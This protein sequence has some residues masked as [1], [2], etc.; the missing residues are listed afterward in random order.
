M[1][2]STKRSKLTAKA[3]DPRPRR[4][5]INR[6]VV[7]IRILPLVCTC[8]SC[9]AWG[10]PARG[11][12][13]L[14]TNEARGIPISFL[15]DGQPSE[16]LLQS[17]P[18]S[19]E[20]KGRGERSHEIIQWQ[21]PATELKVVAETRALA[22]FPAFEWLLRF[23]NAGDADSPI[24][25]QVCVLDLKLDTTAASPVL[26][27]G[28]N[29]DDCSRNSFQPFLK[30]I[31]PGKGEDMS[32]QG[33]RPSSV[34]FPFF[35]VRHGN[36]NLFVAIGWTG[37]WC[38]S[39]TR[40]A[41]GSTRVTAGME[42]VH[43]RLHPGESIRTPRLLVMQA[44]GDRID[45]HN[46]FRRLLLTHYLPKTAGRTWRPAIGAQSFNL[47][48]NGRRPEWNTEA[49]QVA[50][51]KIA[52]QIGCDTHWLDAAWFEGGFP[53]GV[54]NWTVRSAEYPR[55]LKPIGDVCRE[56]GLRFLLWWEPERV[57]AG[58]RISR[59]HPEFVLPGKRFGLFNLG[60]P[61]A[62]RWLTDLLVRQ[63]EEFGVRTYR[64]DFNLSPLP[65]WRAN[66]APDRQGI[67]EIR[68]VEGLYRLWDAIRAAHPDCVMDNC[69][70]GGRRI[71]LEMCMRSIVQTRSDSGLAPDRA[72]WDQAQSCGLSLFLPVHATIGW[73][74]AAYDC[75]SSATAGFLG[76]WDVLD[77]KFPV[78][79]ART[80]IA[81]IRRNQD[82][83]YG[84]FYPLTA[85]TTAADQWMAWQLHLPDGDEGMVLA[86]RRAESPYASLQTKL[87]GLR[88][89]QI[90]EATW[91]DDNDRV[92]TRR[93]AA[94]ELATI[95]IQL[96]KPR[97][98]VLIRYKQAP[99]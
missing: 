86:F 44:E 36:H 22:G 42:L 77:P 30:E 55:G 74:T 11:G 71:D 96:P 31:P 76:E 48:F 43:L 12:V 33:G 34:A 52:R 83:W 40:A 58:T 61:A 68:Y 62:N 4:L 66:D 32:P 25:E 41:D 67:T 29:G 26:L 89:G 79:A 87:R 73:S 47:N 49:G 46:L 18:R 78:E 95:E 5:A 14:W 23:E 97:T 99:G 80:R 88:E 57:I 91:T 37:Q 84:D 85:C 13:G 94:A 27:D 28:I 1:R 15:F 38:A 50:A 56:L 82:F 59:E 20:R 2:I 6:G 54:G 65:V 92:V 21:D 3:G 53:K 8:L 93:L 9:L 16:T 45:A 39:V 7:P 60:D 35:N 19:A 70:A 17:W 90:Y 75:R 64:N 51:A 98:S 63:I 10:D 72:D 69:A 24:L 81:E